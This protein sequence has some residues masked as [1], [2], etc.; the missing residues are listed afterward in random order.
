M[1]YIISGLAIFALVIG[2]VA[3][4]VAISVP[5]IASPDTTHIV[6]GQK[7]TMTVLE[8]ELPSSPLQIVFEVDALIGTTKMHSWESYGPR[9]TVLVTRYEE[10]ADI[11]TSYEER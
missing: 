1:K 11:F 2:S 6:G 9:S 8:S 7:Y 4:A 5:F 10:N 3:P